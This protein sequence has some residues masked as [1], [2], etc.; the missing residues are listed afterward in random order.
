MATTNVQIWDHFWAEHAQKQSL[1]HTL[2]WEVRF[3][4]SRAYANAIRRTVGNLPA[5]R[6]LETGC[7]SAQTLRF[8]T[9]HYPHSRCAAVDFSPEAIMLAKIKHP[10]FAAMQGNSLCLP[11]ASNSFDVSCSVGLIEHF[12]RADAAQICREK[13]RVVRPGGWVAVIVPWKSSVYNLV[14]RRL[15]GKYWPFGEEDP[16][17]RAELVRL[18]M[19]IGLAHVSVDV[20][21]GTTLVVIGQKQAP[22]VPNA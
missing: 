4:F 15:A 8:L 12:T 7:G 13:A 17:R 10:T 16:F 21:Y 14:L 19:E 11:I 6:L 5:P 22:A 20:V 3:L 2:L 9:G 18:M 1:F